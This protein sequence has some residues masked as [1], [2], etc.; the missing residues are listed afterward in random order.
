[1]SRAMLTKTVNHRDGTI[2]FQCACGRMVRN[3]PYHLAAHVSIGGDAEC[4]ICPD[5]DEEQLDAHAARAMRPE[6]KE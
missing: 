5:C 3:L 6:A 4:L 1:M 2:S